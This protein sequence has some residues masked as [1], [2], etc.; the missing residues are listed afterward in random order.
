MFE[1][2]ALCLDSLIRKKDTILL[3]FFF[4]QILELKVQVCHLV[5]ITLNCSY[6]Q[7]IL[8]TCVVRHFSLLMLL[9]GV[10][11][12]KLQS[13]CQSAKPLSTDKMV[14]FG[15]HVLLAPDRPMEGWAIISDAW[16][17]ITE[18]FPL[19]CSP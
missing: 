13:L 5:N 11:T 19:Q 2:N 10:S 1:V 15:T 14:K 16:R 6:S 3:T 7:D 9:K 8:H 17:L 12:N 18:I 4:L